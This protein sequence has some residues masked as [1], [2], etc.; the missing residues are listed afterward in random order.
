MFCGC[1]CRPTGEAYCEMASEEALV[2]AM[3]R[4][5]KLIGSRYIELFA[6]SKAEMLQAWNGGRDVAALALPVAISGWVAC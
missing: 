1:L 4:H 3:R 2:E 6:S 5:K